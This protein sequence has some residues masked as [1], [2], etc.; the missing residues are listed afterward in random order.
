MLQQVA[1]EVQASERQIGEEGK[2]KDAQ[3]VAVL[4][5]GQA[6][7]DAAAEEAQDH[8]AQPFADVP[9]LEV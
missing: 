9:D 2:A 1:D 6:D 8:H 7:D 3:T 5:L 4:P